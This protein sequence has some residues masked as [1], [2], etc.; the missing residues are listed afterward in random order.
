[1]FFSFNVLSSE[2]NI[3]EIEIDFLDFSILPSL[4]ISNNFTSLINL[5]LI[6]SMQ[7]LILL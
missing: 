3:T 7:S 2:F 5:S 1:M 6:E 4:K